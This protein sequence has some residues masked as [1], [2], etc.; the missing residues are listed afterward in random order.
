MAEILYP[1]YVFLFIIHRGWKSNEYATAIPSE[2][3]FAFLPAGPS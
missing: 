3:S 1:P 2:F